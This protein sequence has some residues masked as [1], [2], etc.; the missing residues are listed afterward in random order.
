MVVLLS[1][2]GFMF[3][4]LYQWLTTCDRKTS[5]DSQNE[6]WP[7]FEAEQFLMPIA[8]NLCGV[9]NVTYK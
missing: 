4:R 7:V 5:T 8:W 2:H 1:W 9:I 3:S 6:V